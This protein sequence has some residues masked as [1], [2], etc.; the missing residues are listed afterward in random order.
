MNYNSKNDKICEMVF[1]LCID[2]TA[3]NRALVLP[4]NL[5]FGNLRFG[6]GAHGETPVILRAYVVST[7]PA[8]SVYA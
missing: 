6:R 4:E 3:L 1:A 2:G 8:S 5:L 7:E